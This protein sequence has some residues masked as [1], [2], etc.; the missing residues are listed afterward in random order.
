MGLLKAGSLV[1]F[2]FGLAGLDGSQ[3]A[4]AAR[5]VPLFVEGWMAGEAVVGDGLVAGAAGPGERGFFGSGEPGAAGVGVAVGGLGDL[6][7]DARVGAGRE[8]GQGGADL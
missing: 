7:I 5:R 3:Q 6:M 8:A 4:G 2:E 1:G